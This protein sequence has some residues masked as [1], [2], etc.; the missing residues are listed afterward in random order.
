MP[1][2]AAARFTTSSK[3]SGRRR[4]T[5]RSLRRSSKLAG[6]I[7]EKS[8]SVRSASATN[9]SASSS[10]LKAGQSFFIA[11]HLALVHVADTDG[12]QPRSPQGEDGEH[13]PARLGPPHRP[14]ALL[15][16]ERVVDD[17]ADRAQRL[18][19][20]GQGHAVLPALLPVARVPIEPV[21]PDRHPRHRDAFV[22]GI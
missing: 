17:E 18:L 13:V 4:L 14:V 15:A 5:D 8:Y 21:E 22:Y 3:A 7:V 11:P 6:T 12:P 20:L 19:D 9:R 1:C 16:R 10:V 2:R